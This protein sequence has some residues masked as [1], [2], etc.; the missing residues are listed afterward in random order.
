MRS[1]SQGLLNVQRPPSS[2]P[3]L[4]TP[5]TSPVRTSMTGDPDVPWI[6]RHRGV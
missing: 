4:L 3:V 1:T 6:V 5:T 2:L